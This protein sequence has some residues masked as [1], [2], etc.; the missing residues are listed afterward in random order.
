MRLPLFSII[1]PT[2]ARP[3]QLC[4]CI[5]ALAGLNYP[6]DRFEVIVVD[7]GSEMS[8]EPTVASFRPE[9][10]IRLLVQPNLGPAAARNSGARQA[11]GEFLV[12]TDDDCAPAPDWLRGFADRFER[13]PDYA[14]G[15]EVLNALP[16]NL[17][18]TASQ[19]VTAYVCEYYNA[20]PD[21]TRFFTTNNLAVPA[22][23]FAK[24]GGF[25]T[26]DTAYISE[27]REFCHRWQALGHRLVYAPEAIVYH[28][29]DANLESFYRQH[30]KY[31]TGAVGYHNALKRN[32]EARP[33]L[34]PPAFYLNL[35]RY[36]LKKERGARALWLACLMFISQVAYASGYFCKRLHLC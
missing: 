2:H 30:F 16:D 17:C 1:V 33:K 28:V 25:N 24:I 31:G 4:D 23:S 35:L 3:R 36:P 29:R 5:T 8:L 7:D 10:D 32:G 14:F 34:E 6:R 21:G 18:A 13:F 22:K 26:R 11:R 20:Q 9:L 27:D 19:S 12:F 15:G